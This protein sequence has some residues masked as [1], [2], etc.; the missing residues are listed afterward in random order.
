MLLP[1]PDIGR[2]VVYGGYSK[3]KIKK[4]V[5]KGSTHTDMFVLMQ[6]SEYFS[7]SVWFTQDNEYMVWFTQNSEYLVW[8]THECLI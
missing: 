4:D 2:V 8:F 1:L 3:E 6:E 5:D 7:I